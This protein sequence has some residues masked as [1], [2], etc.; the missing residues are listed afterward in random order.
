MCSRTLSIIS[1]LN[2]RNQEPELYKTEGKILNF[3][4][5]K[6]YINKNN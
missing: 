6:F 2:V 4:Y 3:Y 1:S 5:F